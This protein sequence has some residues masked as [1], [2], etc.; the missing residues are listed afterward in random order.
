MYTEIENENETES[1][2]DINPETME[3]ME[4]EPEADEL[5]QL[6]ERE[7]T[8]R[9]LGESILKQMTILEQKKSEVKAEKKRLEVLQNQLTELAVEK[10]EGQ[11]NMDCERCEEEA[12]RA[13]FERGK[14][15]RI[16]GEERI[17]RWT[18]SP[19]NG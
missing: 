2:A 5:N 10:P 12:I 15:Q 13:E 14:A 4:V 18:T 3:V 17:R 11:M 7:Q 19:V 9:N 1:E 8:I 16:A 6:R